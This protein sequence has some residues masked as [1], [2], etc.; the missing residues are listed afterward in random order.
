MIQLDN[1]AL[2]RSGRTILHGLSTTLEPGA[3][4]VVLGPN[5]SLIHI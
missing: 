3:I 1:L 5:L 4:H 2:A